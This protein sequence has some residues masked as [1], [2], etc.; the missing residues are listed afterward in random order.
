[1]DFERMLAVVQG[2]WTPPGELFTDFPIALERVIRTAL[3]PDPAH[4]FASCAAM[5]EALE[6]V[7]ALEG[8]RPG[9]VA[10]L[11]ASLLPAAVPVVDGEPTVRARR[12]LCDDDAPTRGRRSCSRLWSALAA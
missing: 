7:C 10:D 6:R 5:I 2:A 4:R 1:T 8:W 3:A 12:T 11:M 9:G